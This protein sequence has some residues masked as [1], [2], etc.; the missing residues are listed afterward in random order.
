MAEKE[1]DQNSNDNKP[2]DKVLIDFIADLH[3]SFP[4]S[5]DELLKLFDQQQKLIIEPLLEHIKTVYPKH[6]FNIIYENE[7]IFSTEHSEE[8]EDYD[9][10]LYFL[11]NI[12]FKQLWNLQDVSEKTK[13]AMWKYLQLI[14]LS[15]V[16]DLDTK[17]MF[18][19]TS[20]LFEG[21]NKDD[22]KDKLE[23]CMEQLQTMFKSKDMEDMFSNLGSDVSGNDFSFPTDGSN[24]INLEDILPDAD[25]LHSHISQL[26]GGKIGRLATE[27]AEET[28]KELDVD[29]ENMDNADD[30]FKKVF[31]NPKKLMDIVKKIGGKLDAKMKSGELNQEE[32]VS[33]AGEMMDKFKNMPGMEEI[34]K[35]MGGGD[36]EKMMAQM[37]GEG[38]I[39]ELL[40]QMTGNK[41]GKFDKGA[42]TKHMNSNNTRQRLLKKL[43]EKRNAEI[44]QS[45]REK[46]NAE[47]AEKTNTNTNTNTVDPENAID[48]SWIEE[49]NEKSTNANNNGNGNGNKKKGKKKRGKK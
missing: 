43:E 20:K 8:N 49:F 12:D 19:D 41:K 14:L 31:Q 17:D 29:L 5:K 33:E 16:G 28:A 48:E 24:N 7:S 21:I 10:P 13:Q 34:M 2:I 30:M 25:E 35:K 26:M 36:I 47:K 45:I 1:H 44:A 15:T 38:G 22:F 3:R 37:G 4:E 23:T 46:L 39:A 6:F 32:L 27:I 40:K 9:K 42:F 18:G 11:P